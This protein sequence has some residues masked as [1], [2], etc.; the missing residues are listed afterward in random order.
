MQ[1]LCD[2]VVEVKKATKSHGRKKG[3]SKSKTV[4]YVVGEVLHD[5]F[6]SDTGSCIIVNIWLFLGIPCVTPRHTLLTL[7]LLGEHFDFNVILGS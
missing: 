2:V 1:K 5:K 7:P 6:E 4:M 3:K